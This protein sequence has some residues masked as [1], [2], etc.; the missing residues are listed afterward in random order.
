MNA[1]NDLRQR[2]RLSSA[3]IMSYR[4]CAPVFV[5]ICCIDHS[6]KCVIYSVILLPYMISGHSKHSQRLRHSNFSS[7]IVILNVIICSAMH[8]QSNPVAWNLQA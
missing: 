6:V 7:K 2:Y 4:G 5:S 8:M 3:R 1:G